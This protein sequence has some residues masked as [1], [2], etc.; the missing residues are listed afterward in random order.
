[1]SR[2]KIFEASVISAKEIQVGDRLDISGKTRVHNVM[3]RG[4]EVVAGT[5]TRGSG[6]GGVK[7]WHPDAEVK[8]YR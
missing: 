5:K 7:S 3:N 8:V 6:S 4:H 2:R 1:M